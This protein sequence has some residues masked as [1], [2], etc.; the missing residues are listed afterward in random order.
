MRHLSRTEN[1]FLGH[2]AAN[3]TLGILRLR[4]IRDDRVNEAVNTSHEDEVLRWF[5]N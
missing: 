2:G 1:N 5:T 4:E 3:V